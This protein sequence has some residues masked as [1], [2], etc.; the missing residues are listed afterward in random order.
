MICIYLKSFLKI[1]LIYKIK[2]R[3]KIKINKMDIVYEESIDEK[4]KEKE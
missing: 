4:E 2:F 1:F 3:I